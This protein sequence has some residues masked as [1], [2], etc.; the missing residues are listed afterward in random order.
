VIHAQEFFRRHDLPEQDE[1]RALSASWSPRAAALVLHGLLPMA[2]A[3]PL[4]NPS[5]VR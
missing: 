2:P 5:S 4:Q 3:E 1:S